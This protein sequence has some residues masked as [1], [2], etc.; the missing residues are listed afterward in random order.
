GDYSDAAGYGIVGTAVNSPSFE[1]GKLGQ[2]I[3]LTTTKDGL[4]DNYVT[5]GYPAEL[6]FGSE[7]TG[8]ATDFSIAFWAK[9]YHQ[10]EDQA[11]IANKNWDDGKNLGWVLATENDGMK[12]NLKDSLSSRRDSAH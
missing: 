11:F 9:V 10:A 4:V 3:R 8:D 2:G 12:W 6:R 1:S 7:A 5:L